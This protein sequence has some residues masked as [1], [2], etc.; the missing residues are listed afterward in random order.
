MKEFLILEPGTPVFF[1][2]ENDQGVPAEKEG[3]IQAVL[4]DGSS[5]DLSG[6]AYDVLV[7]AERKLYRNVPAET[8]RELTAASGVE[9]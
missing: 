7:H 3:E 8:V 5:P 1:L 6:L 2:V 4:Q 9:D